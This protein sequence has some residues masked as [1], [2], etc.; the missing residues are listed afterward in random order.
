MA[1]LE[2][3]LQ[4]TIEQ[5]KALLAEGKITGEQFSAM[6]L[7]ID[8]DYKDEESA[9]ELPTEGAGDA[10]ATEDSID[11]EGRIQRAVDRAT[12]KIGNENKTLRRQ[13]DEIKKTKLSAE[14]LAEQDR[15]E[16]EQEL[17]DREK[18]LQDRENRL[19]AVKAIKTA[20]LDDG[21]DQS[22]ALIDFVMG[23]TEADIEMKVKA[24]GSLVKRFVK[25]EVDKTFKDGG[26]IPERGKG[27][28]GDSNPWKVD[29]RN[30]TEQMKIE[31]SNPEL[32]KQ[33]K[34]AA[35]Y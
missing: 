22:L 13:L 15:K 34:A 6:A 3:M 2:R 24:F 9:P 23:E 25:S 17:A 21:S 26:K 1:E 10:N 35:G 27:S 14:E 12:N 11:L 29:T 32:A 4:M 16:R 18:L 31:V 8:P 30:I 28:V 33:L 5:L 19:Y 7:A 20:G